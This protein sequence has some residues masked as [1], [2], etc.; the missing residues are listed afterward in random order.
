MPTIEQT[1][2]PRYPC[3]CFVSVAIPAPPGGTTPMEL[4]HCRPRPG[5]R[6]RSGACATGRLPEVVGV[7]LLDELP[8]LVDDLLLL[9]GL[10]RHRVGGVV[11]DLGAGEDRRV[12]PHGEGDGV[13]G[14]ARHPPGLVAG[15][16]LDLGEEGALPELGD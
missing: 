3:S 14:P 7:D 16:Q 11:E 12:D 8:E 5:V 1:W 4:R 15:A 2:G 10:P 13:G 9:L 6:Q